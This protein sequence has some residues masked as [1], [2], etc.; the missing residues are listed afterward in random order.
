MYRTPRYWGVIG[1]AAFFAVLALVFGEQAF[2]VC[3]GGLLTWAVAAEGV[4]RDRVRTVAATVECSYELSSR[5]V[6]A[7]QPVS[8][9]AAVTTTPL[10]FGLDVD[11]QYPAAATGDSAETLHVE[12]G[13]AAERVS[14]EFRMPFAGT[15][16]IGPATATV[17]S[18]YGLFK[19][20]VEVSGTESV[21]VEPQRLGE[22]HVGQGG[23]EFPVTVGEHGTGTTGPGMTPAGTRVYQPGDPASRINWKATARLDDV[24]VNEF[25][26]ETVRPLLIF[27]DTREVAGGPGSA[28]AGEY[29]RHIAAALVAKAAAHGDPVALYEVTAEGVEASPRLS[30]SPQQYTTVRDRL[31]RAD[32]GPDTGGDQPASTRPVA[33]TSTTVPKRLRQDSSA[34]GSTLTPFFAGGTTHLRHIAEDPLTRTVNTYLKPGGQGVRV[35]ILAGDAYRSELYETVQ[36]AGQRSSEVLVFTTPAVLFEARTL[37]EVTDVYQQY[38][39]FERYRQQLDRIENVTAFEIAPRDELNVVLQKRK[40][41]TTPHTPTQ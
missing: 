21:T 20:V 19:E 11:P 41:S 6:G 32:R 18:P 27:L 39:E 38:T 25:E 4:F 16:E 35:A 15:Y 13:A 34:F 24:Y 31:Y 30:A 17:T 36:V 7:D 5:E 2:I 10:R 28:D 8:V 40:R 1:L 3:S 22:V 29:R 37:G 14:A 26:I 23:D 12:P 9:T 33:E